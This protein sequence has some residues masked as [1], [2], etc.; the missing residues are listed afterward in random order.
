VYAAFPLFF[1]AVQILLLWA[2][3]AGHLLVLR[4]VGVT[5]HYLATR[6]LSIGIA[7]SGASPRD[8]RFVAVAGPGTA[9]VLCGLIA[10]VCVG[11]GA[12]GSALFVGACGLLHGYSLLPW[13]SDGRMLWSGENRGMP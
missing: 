7:H 12:T 10:A 9:I 8:S 13:T 11:L 2:H 5:D 3:E 1:V 6:G 4:R